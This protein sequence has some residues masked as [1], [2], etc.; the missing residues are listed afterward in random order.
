VACRRRLSCQQWTQAARASHHLRC[1]I[2]TG[3]W[4]PSSSKYRWSSHLSQAH[5]WQQKWKVQ[6]SYKQNKSCNRNC[7]CIFYYS[8]T[9]SVQSYKNDGEVQSIVWRWDGTMNPSQ[10]KELLPPIHN[11]CSW[12]MY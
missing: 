8:T 4:P 2:T 11:T 9:L 1:S 10:E 6:L 7:I 5:S 3:P 12:F